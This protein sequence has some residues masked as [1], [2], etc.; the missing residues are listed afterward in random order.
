MSL[1]RLVVFILG[2]AITLLAGFL[3]LW[4]SRHFPGAHLPD[5][6]SIEGVITSGLIVVIPMILSHLKIQ[7]WLDGWQK[8]EH[9]QDQSVQAALDGSFTHFL[10]A[11][12]AKT[13]VELPSGAVNSVTVGNMSENTTTT[14]PGDAD[15]G[16]PPVAQP[17][18]FEGVGAGE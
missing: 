4:L 16:P 14:T 15:V 8:W 12:A 11:V 3:S 17:G 10:E 1:N 9:R 2:P 13:G 5:Q 6:K 18:A 7:K